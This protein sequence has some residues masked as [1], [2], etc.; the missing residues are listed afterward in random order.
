MHTQVRNRA[1]RVADRIICPTLHQELATSVLVQWFCLMFKWSEV[2]ISGTLPDIL[3][4]DFRSFPYYH[5][6]IV[7]TVHSSDHDNISNHF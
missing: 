4:K 5:H 3:S 6:A 2:L 1:A 7:G